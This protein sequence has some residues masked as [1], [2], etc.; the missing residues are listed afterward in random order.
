[1][2]KIIA[3]GNFLCEN[4]IPLKDGI[5]Q[6]FTE[7]GNEE[8]FD[9][10]ELA[11]KF[12]G[13]QNSAKFISLLFDKF[14]TLFSIT[15][16]VLKSKTRKEPIIFYKHVFRYIL[17]TTFNV[18]LQDT[19][20]ALNNTDHTSAIHSRNLVRDVLKVQTSPEDYQMKYIY[21]TIM[22]SLNNN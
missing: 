15:P 12:F 17:V 7:E 4:Y 16:E 10:G 13:K 1:M 8:R 14:L 6:S 5:W 18:S 22:K 9:T 21:D 3:F 19:A 11:V 20:K 2:D